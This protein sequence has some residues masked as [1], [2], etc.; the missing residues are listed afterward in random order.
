M[1]LYKLSTKTLY[2]L[3]GLYNLCI[4]TIE[5][6]PGGK[7]PRVK[8]QAVHRPQNATNTS[9]KCYFKRML[10]ILQGGSINLLESL[11]EDDGAVILNF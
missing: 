9:R 11:P 3:M 5:K 7:V 6:V 2:K 4:P 8:P 10:R 1:G